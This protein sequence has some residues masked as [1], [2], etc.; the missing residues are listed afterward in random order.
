MAAASQSMLKPATEQSFLDIGSETSL[1]I[2]LRAFDRRRNR[3]RHRCC[4]CRLHVQVD[5][6]HS[7][8]KRH[9]AGPSSEL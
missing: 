7:D 4:G 8:A 5:V 1:K 9:N 3:L 2:A 6:G